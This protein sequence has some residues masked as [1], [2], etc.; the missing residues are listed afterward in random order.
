M[1][2]NIEE[3][4][5]GGTNDVFK[6]VEPILSPNWLL[7][8]SINYSLKKIFEISFRNRYVSESFLE[9][10]NQENLTIPGFFVADAKVTIRFLK[11]QSL[12][13]MVNNIFDKLYFISGA[14]IDNNFDGVFDGPSY[15]VQPPRHYYLM[16]KFK[17]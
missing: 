16:L 15:L 1:Q 13:L 17:F 9:L 4:T 12:S 5:P 3:F 8:G 2:S 7:N 14:P 10:T 6:D 11:N